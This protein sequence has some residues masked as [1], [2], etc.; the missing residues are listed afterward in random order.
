MNALYPSL[1]IFSLLF[2]V[3]CGS[4]DDTGDGSNT[5]DNSQ[6]SDETQTPPDFD[7]TFSGPV[8]YTIDC[9]VGSDMDTSTQATAKLSQ[10]GDVVTFR[11][12]SDVECP[13]IEADV[14][15]TV[16]AV[17][18]HSCDFLLDSGA[19]KT[20]RFTSEGKLE[21]LDEAHSQLD[22]LVVMIS[23]SPNETCTYM[24]DGVLTREAEEEEEEEEEF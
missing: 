1:I 17:R 12:F 6:N 5:G 20:Q 4:A 7:G 19:T 9:Q 22:Y 10:S 14:N 21:F 24:L 18:E 2:S 3:G 23:S 8:R 15:G 11:A 16:A 13:N